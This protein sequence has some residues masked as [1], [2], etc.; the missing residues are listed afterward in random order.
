MIGLTVEIGWNSHDLIAQKKRI[1]IV[2]KHISKV[3]K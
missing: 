2:I 1:I 3:R